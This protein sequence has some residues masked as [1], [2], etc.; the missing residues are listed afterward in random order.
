M[1][2]QRRLLLIV[3]DHDLSRRAL[4]KLLERLGWEV[5]AAASIAEGL[6]L[7]DQEPDCLVLDLMLPDGDGESVLRAV[8]E[9]HL[10]TRVVVATGTGDEGRLDAVRG[11]RPDAILRK[12]LKVDELCVAC[13]SDRAEPGSGRG[14]GRGGSDD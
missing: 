1:D 4:A 11:L 5:R 10:R 9:R 3:E 2:R 14:S 13:E 7:L 12:P 6:E 8:R